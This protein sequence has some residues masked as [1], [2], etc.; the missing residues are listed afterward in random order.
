M[1][2]TQDYFL[3]SLYIVGSAVRCCIVVVTAFVVTDV[4]VAVSRKNR[5]HVLKCKFAYIITNICP[6]YS[7]SFV[8]TTLA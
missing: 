1:V 5:G 6:I 7:I 3:P 8:S 4:V 2:C